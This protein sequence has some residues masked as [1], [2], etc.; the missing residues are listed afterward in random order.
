MFVFGNVVAHASAQEAVVYVDPVSYTAPEVGVGF[1]INVSIANVTNLYAYHFILWYNTT[2][3]D[4]LEVELPPNHFLTPSL[5]PNNIFTT[6]EIDDNYNAT[7][8][9]VGVMTTLT[10]SEPPKNGSG[11]LATI[12]FNATNPDGPSPLKLYFPG[13]TYPVK[14]SDPDANPIAC[15]AVD[16]TVEVIPEFPSFLILPLFMIA[17]LLAVIV[18]ELLNTISSTKERVAS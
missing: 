15:T 1:T 18:F 2:L 5:N 12:S 10:G 8:G 4:G 16:G 7:H 17:T 3:L 11:I 9:V 13:F 6:D 14:L